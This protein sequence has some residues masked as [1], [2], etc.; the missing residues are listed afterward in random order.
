M[1]DAMAEERV[2]T[3]AHYFSK[4]QVG[5]VK[6]TAEIKVGE[7]LHFRGHTTDFQQEI[8]SME[9][10]HRRVDSAASGDEIAIKVD[11][12]VRGGD[13]VYKIIP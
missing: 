13:E 8:A 9:V 10:E 2:G 4:P 1:E 7:T 5:V 3:I 11:Q 12:R 6:L